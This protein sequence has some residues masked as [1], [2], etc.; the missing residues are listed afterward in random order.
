MR[1]NWKSGLVQL[2][3][4]M[5]GEVEGE[6]PNDT[7]WLRRV[8][9]ANGWFSPEMVQRSLRA[10]GEMLTE[11]NLEAWLDKYPEPLAPGQQVGCILAGNLPLVGWLDVLTTVLAGHRALVK[12][13]SSDALL[14]PRL[15]QVWAGFDDRISDQIHF[16]PATFKSADAMLATGSNNSRRYFEHYFS[17]KPHLIRHQRTGVAFLDGS[18]TDD[19]LAGLADDA[20]AYYGLGCRST[21]KV[22]V[23]RGFDLNRIFGAFYP[24]SGLANHNKFANNYDYHKAVWLLNQEPMLDNGFLLLKE[25]PGL[26]SPVGTLF[27]A[28]YDSEVEVLNML[29]ASADDIQVVTTRSVRLGDLQRVLP[30][31]VVPLGSAQSPKAWDYPDG[32]D[33]MDFLLSLSSRA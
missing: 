2:G 19:E 1:N 32:L 9:G 14:I 21:T 26:V 3:G 28:P 10:H 29:A 16:A 23:P 17:H 18:E 33:T 15:V 20:L 5:R 31:P 8:E 22:F 13:A 7:D 6:G 30:S 4:W 12:L 25:D 27:W 11:S 24:W